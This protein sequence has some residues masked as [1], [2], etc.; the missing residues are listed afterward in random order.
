MNSSFSFDHYEMD[1]QSGKIH[2]FYSLTSDGDVYHFDEKI[3]L[4]RSLSLNGQDVLLSKMLQSIHIALGMSYWK[5]FC[6]RT[7]LF[8]S[9]QLSKLQAEF[10]NTVYTKGF[11]ELYYKNN[12]DYR[13][14]INFPYDASLYDEPTNCEL[15]DRSLVGIGGGK[16]SIVTATLLQENDKDFDAFIVE[17]QKRYSL[18]NEV[19]QKL[20]IQEVIIQRK[21]DPQ[22]FELNKDTKT[23]N[24]HVPISVIY[25]FLGVLAA[26]VY[27]Y[28]NVIVSNER[29]A[30]DGNIKYLGEIINH[31]WS[32]S[33]EFEQLFQDVMAKTLT[34]SIQYFSLLRPLSELQ[35]AQLFS[36]KVQ[37]H[38]LFS[39]CNRNFSITKSSSQI[40]CGQCPK[41]AFT[42]L[43]MAA[44]SA[45]E[46]VI[47]IFGEN[48]FNKQSLVS[49]YKQLLG[50]EGVKPFECVG[51]SEEAIV[52]L[53]LVHERGAFEDSS[54]MK[55]LAQSLLA[56]TEK[57]NHMK[58]HLFST[59]ESHMMPNDFQSIISN[60]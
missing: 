42:F 13:N 5:L 51:T 60:L 6:P 56:N 14:L 33:T 24:G 19:S 49:T 7:L 29:S 21:I 48:Y 10:W 22:L 17:T 45:K 39:S 37:F 59:K 12:I 23:F 20:G 53:S 25:A 43:L 11:G 50:I 57:V 41:C 36:K 31:Q 28:S 58:H 18:T 8:K 44:F 16:D 30:D 54:I 38:N 35:I 55:E 4:S 34:P 32:K 9:Y 2:F 52:A 26:Y 15:K 27:D 3:I 40:W 46:S 1:P 47:R